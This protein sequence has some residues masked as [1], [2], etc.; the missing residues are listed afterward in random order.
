MPHLKSLFVNNN[1]IQRLNGI[2]GL[3]QLEQLYAQVNQI[4][5]IEPLRKLT[6]LK[7]VYVNF[8]AL[9]TLDGLTR[10]QAGLLRTF[11]C[12]PNEQLPDR[13]VI[14]VERALGIRCRSLF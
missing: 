9:K 11:F 12:L 5:S 7:E 6:A 13:E 2:E 3:T 10:K 14:R 1:A 4:T 8:N